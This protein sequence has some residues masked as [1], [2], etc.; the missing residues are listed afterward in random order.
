MV[1]GLGFTVALLMNQL[2][3]RDNPIALDQGVLGVLAGSGIS[4]VV[5]AVLI[6]WRASVHRRRIAAGV[7]EVE[8]DEDEDG[9]PDTPVTKTAVP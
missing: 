4:L 9:E 8:I 7:E 3:F 5:G 6:A 2:A 1:G